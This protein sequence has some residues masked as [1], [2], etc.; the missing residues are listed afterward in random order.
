M[1]SCASFNPKKSKTKNSTKD[2]L[3]IGIAVTTR[4]LVKLAIPSF[5]TKHP[6][7]NITSYI[8]ET[9]N[10]ISDV[11]AG[12]T[13]VAVTTRN[14]KTYELETLP[15][16]IATPIGMDGLV[17]TVSE[18]LPITNLNFDD[19]VSIWIEKY[20]NWN[21]LGG[22]NLAITVIGRTKNY[23]PIRLFADFLHLDTKDVDG[24]LLYRQKDSEK[25]TETIFEAT[26]TDTQALEKLLNTQGA[27]TYFPLQILHNY[28]AKNLP[29]KA[30]SFYGIK[31][32]YETISNGSYHIHR[33]LNCI[34]NGK[35]TGLT[36]DYVH[37]LLSNEGQ[38]LV[39]VSGFLKLKK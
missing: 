7:A 37:F 9:G 34:T 27:I 6:K 10:V 1:I 26:E 14:L 24:G 23:D 33:T 12:K 15:S 3:T 18:N 2:S 5:A 8:H 28:K 36:N 35:P 38:E 19:I 30:L 13:S 17:L 32:S 16:L 25:W 29:I 4:H 11:I 20:T 31:A 21:Q 39:E 22:P